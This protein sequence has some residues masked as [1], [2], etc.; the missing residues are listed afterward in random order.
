MLKLSGRGWLIGGAGLLVIILFI[1]W[2][3][4][5]GKPVEVWVVEAR[6]LTQS[7]VLTGRVSTESRVVLGSTIVG[8]VTSV[9]VR[10][11][12]DVKAGQLIA[13]LEDA[14]LT[15]TLDQADA[16]WRNAD[17]RL[18]SQRSVIAPVAMQQREQAGSNA[19]TSAREFVRQQELFAKGFIGQSRL[20]ESRRVNEVAQSQ[21]AAAEAQAQANATGSELKQAIARVAEARAAREL[22]VSRL[23]QTRIVAPAAGRVL[24]RFVEPGQILQ[25]GA[26]VASMNLAGPTQLW[27]QVDEKFLSQLKVGQAAIVVADAFAGQAFLATIQSISPTID[28][29]RGSVEVKFAVATPPAFLRNDMTLSIEVE[30]ARREKALAIPAELVTTGVNPTVM[31]LE[32]RVAAKRAVKLGIRSSTYVEVRDGLQAGDAVIVDHTIAEGVRVHRGEDAAKKIAPG[33]GNDATKI[34]VPEK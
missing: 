13:T 12:A 33:M 32:S 2:R 5:Y 14:E 22:A 1:A 26:R 21:L 11:G 28:V 15:A 10:E 34:P 31:V 17:A 25:A 3:A 30:T 27:A 29:L 24:E 23:A 8:R 4:W 18:S 6:A 19:T 16:A 7:V 20:D 9:A